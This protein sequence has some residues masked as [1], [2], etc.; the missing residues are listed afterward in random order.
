MENRRDS[1]L[2]DNLLPLFLVSMGGLLVAHQ[3][4]S[5]G[6]GGGDRGDHPPQ[7]FLLVV[8]MNK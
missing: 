5:H 8:V 3:A 4:W 6:G 7:M 2:S 1:P